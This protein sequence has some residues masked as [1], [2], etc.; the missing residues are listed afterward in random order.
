MP[1]P[2]ASIRIQVKG[3]VFRDAKALT[4]KAIEGAVREVVQ[5]SE[6]RLNE[7][8][9]PRPAP[10]VYLTVAQA[11]GNGWRT[12][13]PSAP[14]PSSSG[15]YRK[16]LHTKIRG[17]FGRIDDGGVLYGPWLE[18]ISARNRVTRFKGYASFRKTR[19]WAQKQTKGILRKHM[20]HLM[21]KL[22]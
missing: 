20:A 9:M 19:Q 2:Q 15:H 12:R 18:G 8:L 7:V 17:L 4:K 21:R 11:R 6:E 1:A 13:N 10:G 22:N 16:N 5:K 14:D 3:R